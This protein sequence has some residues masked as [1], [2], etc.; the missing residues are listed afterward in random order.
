MRE[1]ESK[2]IG[3]RRAGMPTQTGAA[4]LA[5][6]DVLKASGIPLTMEQVDRAWVEAVQEVQGEEAAAKVA[7]VRGVQL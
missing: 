5:K 4:Y 3:G 1:P 7:K 2:R 6:I